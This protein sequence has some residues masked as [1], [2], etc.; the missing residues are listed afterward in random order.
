MIHT[1]HPA[2]QFDNP[3]DASEFS[4]RFD[5][6]WPH[7]YFDAVAEFEGLLNRR[8][9]EH[10]VHDFLE[11]HPFLIPGIDSLHH[12]PY[13][14]I[15]VTKLSLGADFISDFA[16]VTSNSQELCLT[17]VE[18]ESPRKQLFRKDGSFHRDYLDSRQQITDWLFWAQHNMRDALDQ[19]GTLFRR[20]RLR[21]YS[22]GFRGILVFGRRSE[23][24]GDRKRQERWAGEPGALHPNLHTM[25]YDRLLE[26]ASILRPK[27]DNDKVAVCTYSDRR[28]QVKYVCS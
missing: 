2:L 18:I 8:V 6:T 23:I 11:R 5:A 17:G 4:S 21:D 3:G 25:T 12:G 16:Y 7:R 22:I 24:E 27:M 26:R 15:V 20:H 1:V 28:F 14:G 19:W 10:P 9:S 13:A